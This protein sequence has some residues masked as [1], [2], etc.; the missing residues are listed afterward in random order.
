M[1]KVKTG[2]DLGK[3]LIYFMPNNNYGYIINQQGETY[4]FFVFTGLKLSQKYR[5]VISA[6]KVNLSFCN[7]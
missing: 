2:T 5:A 3:V 1:T 7:E 4:Q 6:K